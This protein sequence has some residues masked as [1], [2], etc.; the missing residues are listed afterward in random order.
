MEEQLEGRNAVLEALRSGRPVNKVLIAN[1]TVAGPV[2]EIIALAKKRGIPVQ[3]V[4][5]K[6]ITYLGVTAATQGVIA[7]AAPKDY[8]TLES[9]L[10]A[11][12]AKREDPL[13][14]LLDH[15][16]DP[17]NFGSLLRTADSAGVHGVII[18]KNRTVQLTAAVSRVSAGAVEYVP[19]ARVTNL[20][21]T[22]DD[23]KQ[24]GLWI[25]GADM[26]ADTNYYDADLAGPL[27]LVIGSE[28]H[29]ISRLVKAKCDFTVRIPMRGSI[30]SLNAAVAG[31]ILLYEAVRQ[32]QQKC[33][34]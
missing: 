24:A 21:R 18:P 28:G 20:S 31:A 26:E 8:V 10:Q 30:A 27:G 25:A 19:V 32:R 15:L 29:G 11:A 1:G 34:K 12:K 14:V 2:R 23:L 6:Q 4:D 5:R 17:Q 13:L 22:L 3:E 16:E 33:A 7:Y 9:I